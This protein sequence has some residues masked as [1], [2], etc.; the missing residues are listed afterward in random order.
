M[1]SFKAIR[2]EKD[3]QGYRAVLGELDRH[4]VVRT[5][6]HPRDVPFNGKPRGQVESLNASERL[7]V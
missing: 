7:R 3:E 1:S 2:I 4:S 6:V 5:F